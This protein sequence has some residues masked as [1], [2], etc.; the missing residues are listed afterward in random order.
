MLM[1]HAPRSQRFD[2][3]NLETLWWPFLETS[4]NLVESNF[5]QGVTSGQK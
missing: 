4:V 2:V 1:M 3:V 5:P